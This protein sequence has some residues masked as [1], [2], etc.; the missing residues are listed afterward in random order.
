[1]QV[2]ADA[3]ETR[4]FLAVAAGS[5][6]IAAV[7]GMGRPRPGPT[8]PGELDALRASPGGELLRGIRHLVQAEPDPGWLSRDDVRAGLRHVGAA[9]LA[10]DLLGDAPFSSPPRSRRSAPCPR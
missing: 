10:Y 9:G 7:V 2:L 6:T 1:M 8:S 4:D 5:E 3:E